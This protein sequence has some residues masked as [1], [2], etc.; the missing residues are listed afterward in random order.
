MVSLCCA[1]LCSYIKRFG[2]HP[3]ESSLKQDNFSVLQAIVLLTFSQLL[4]F[5]CKRREYYFYLHTWAPGNKRKMGSSQKIS[6][7]IVEFAQDHR[8]IICKSLTKYMQVLENVW[9]NYILCCLSSFSKDGL[10]SLEAR[11]F[12]TSKLVLHINHVGHTA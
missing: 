9:M 11:I 6:S 4:N 3:C 10:H 2:F 1:C 5:S 8:N 12:I 7:Q